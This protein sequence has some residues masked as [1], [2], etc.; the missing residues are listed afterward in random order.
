MPKI[1]KFERE[2]RSRY[3]LGV[4]WVNHRVDMKYAKKKKKKLNEEPT[5]A[6]L[7]VYTE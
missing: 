5:V 6:T 7:R 3:P 4:R 1:K 2:T